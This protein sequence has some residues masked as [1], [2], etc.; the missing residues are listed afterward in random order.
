MAL[1]AGI[2]I[3]AFGGLVSL[4]LW[5][6]FPTA[7]FTRMGYGLMT[8]GGLLAIA[9]VASHVLALGIAGLAV[10]L[11]GGILG[12]TGGLRKELRLTPFE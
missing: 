3:V 10:L 6:K 5:K 4:L 1:V 9:W 11:L 12:M 7:R 8:V 2:F